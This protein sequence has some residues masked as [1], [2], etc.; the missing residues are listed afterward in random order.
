MAWSERKKGWVMVG[1]FCGLAVLALAAPL[2]QR[3]VLHRATAFDSIEYRGHRYP[4]THKY[5]S[6]T[7]YKNDPDN[8]APGQEQAIAQALTAAPINPTYPTQ[9][10]LINA[11]GDIQFP[12]YGITFF[13]GKA[14]PEGKRLQ[15][16]AIEIPRAE[17]DRLLVF[18][19]PEPTKSASMD[20]FLT[21]GPCDL[22]DDF[23]APADARITHVD[24]D[25][26]QL[27][28]R[29]SNGTEVMRRPMRKNA[30]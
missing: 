2:L 10:A 30:P 20:D 19:T 6:F 16:Y 22:L 7:R 4:L 14:Q 8:L 13:G 29:H 12:G 17:R 11:I 5:E 21:T 23:V 3:L 15:A 18:R 1:V 26:D 28:Y 24:E 9:L 25:G 27:V